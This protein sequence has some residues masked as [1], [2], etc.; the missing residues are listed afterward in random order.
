MT[1]QT[2]MSL[3]QLHV[4]EEMRG[5]EIF[6][7]NDKMIRDVVGPY[8]ESSQVR[9]SCRA[10]GGHPL[11]EVR[12]VSR[13]E[14][15]IHPRAL[16]LPDSPMPLGSDRPVTVRSAMLILRELTRH[17]DGRRLRC[18]ARSTN[19]TLG[20]HK[21]VT[22][23]MHLPPLRVEIEGTDVPLRAG[24]EASIMCRSTGS[25]PPATLDLKIDGSTG[26]KALPPQSSLDQNT[27]IR[28]GRLLPSSEDN[29]R[30]ITCTAKNPLVPDYRLSATRRLQVHFAPE[31]QARL[32]PALNPKNIK[33]G[34]D[35]YFVCHIRANPPESRVQWLHQGRPLFTVK[36]KGVLAQA[37]NLV[38]QRVSR[39]AQGKYQCTATNAIN[40]V[41]S[42]PATLD[43]MC[44]YR[45]PVSP[46]S[47]AYLFDPAPLTLPHSSAHLFTLFYLFFS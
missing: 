32:A 22:I 28:R 5:L 45:H 11:P 23:S 6:D 10:Y 16:P 38:L 36:E 47:R 46:A 26:F 19:L 31:V 37:R 8:Q 43:V 34:E 29:G 30:T 17:D 40:T 24:V 12:W 4:H 25:K 42:A 27:T 39:H 3:V 13:G 18:E 21:E 2:M 44:E 20:L 15:L 35:V 41:T 14:E 1:S 9:L 7:N 33:E